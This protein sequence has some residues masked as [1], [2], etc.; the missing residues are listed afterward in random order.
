MTRMNKR[1]LRQDAFVKPVTE[2]LEV[3]REILRGFGVASSVQTNLQ[4]SFSYPIR[5]DN[6][7]V[8]LAV[9]TLGCASKNFPT[10]Y[11]G[12]PLS[13]KKPSA[14]DLVPWIEKIAAKLPGWK[15]ELLNLSGRITLIK[16]VLSA[17]PVY[18]F[19]ALNAPKWVIKAIDKIRRIFCEKEERRLEEAKAIVLYLGIKLLGLLI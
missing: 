12:L 8:E 17:I 11:L 16:S 19:I 7:R 4:K 10:T 2:D 6:E 13:S 14:G 9:Q 15:V 18:L 1:G 5:C 3:T